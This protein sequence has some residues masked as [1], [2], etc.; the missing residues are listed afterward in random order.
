MPRASSAYCRMGGWARSSSSFSCR[1]YPSAQ[2]VRNCLY[3]SRLRPR[4]RASARPC[5]SPLRVSKCS[6]NGPDEDLDEF[7][8][9]PFPRRLG[10]PSVT[11]IALL[12]LAI[13][14]IKYLLWT[15]FSS[16]FIS[17][18]V[19]AFWVHYAFRNCN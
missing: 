2:D 10:P 7:T 1:G 3:P 19:I 4:E 18:S 13:F 11:D 5:L 15:I 14:H 16:E 9:F 6:S 8:D 12:P 17:A